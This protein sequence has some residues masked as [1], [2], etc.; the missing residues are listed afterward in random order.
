M[1]Q[2][3]R[4]ITQPLQYNKL[5]A[6]DEV[7]FAKDW[8]SLGMRVNLY[9]VF[10]DCQHPNKKFA[11][12]FSDSINT[13]NLSTSKGPYIYG[14]TIGGDTVSNQIAGGVINWTGTNRWVICLYNIVEKG[15]NI[16]DGAEVL[17]MKDVSSVVIGG[18]SGAITTIKSIYFH[19]LNNIA[20]CLFQLCSGL[21]GK[22]TIP[23]GTVS[24]PRVI[25]QSASIDTV[26]IPETVNSFEY[27]TNGRQFYFCPN[28]TKLII[29]TIFIDNIPT[30]SFGGTALTEITVPLGY[31]SNALYFAWTQSLTSASL[32]ILIE[33]ITPNIQKT[34]TI[35][36]NNT[37][38][39]G[40]NNK[41]RLI[42]DTSL[43]AN[44]SDY[45]TWENA[46]T[47]KSIIGGYVPCT[48]VVTGNTTISAVNGNQK[49]NSF[50]QN[51]NLKIGNGTQIYAYT[52]TSATDT[53]FNIT[54]AVVAGDNGKTYIIEVE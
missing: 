28:L 24:I 38:S 49:A 14:E 27:T 17:Y 3:N 21:R 16:A 15:S 22:F 47:N 34:I 39:G 19:Q 54:P 26:E 2:Y 25:A 20:N 48:A 42:D 45:Q 1:L 44:F 9:G 35:G 43:F 12:T 51:G 30:D 11:Y 40:K 52:R 53:T 13:L 29:K 32:K 33:N 41:Q 4:D 18:T 31:D 36:I 10:N 7:D 50:R 46:Q 6:I 5:F 8:M 23:F 37:V